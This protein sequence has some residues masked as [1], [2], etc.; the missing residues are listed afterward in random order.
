MKQ[1][2]V[3]VNGAKVIVELELTKEQKKIIYEAAEN[4]RDIASVFHRPTVDET[5]FYA[6]P[7]H[8]ES[9]HIND[10]T[11]PFAAEL[12]KS[13]NCYMDSEVA[14]KLIEGDR[15]LRRLRR[16]SNLNRKREI[17][18]T[19]T[20][21]YTITYNY[22][23]KSLECGLTGNWF[24]LGDVVFDSEETAREAINLY[25]D[26]LIWYFTEVAPII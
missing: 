3:E 19:S 18:L 12:Y 15:L 2:E 20:G 10:E 4:A 25:S 22:A 23:E 1:V 26:E 13:C 24:A 11:I 6:G 9:L 8:M 7:L 14:E 21:G 16:F 17:D 5:C